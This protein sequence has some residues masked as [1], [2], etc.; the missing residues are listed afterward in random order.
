VD[1]IVA[2]VNQDSGV[3]FKMDLDVS[4]REMVSRIAPIAIYYTNVQSFIDKYTNFEYGFVHHALCASIDTFVQEYLT[5]IAQ[6]EHVFRKGDMTMQRFWF[7]V[8]PVFA[9]MKALDGLTKSIERSGCKGGAL[10]SLLYD[11]YI[12]LS[13]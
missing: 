1:G 7:Y 2:Q 9:R 12:S 11:R 5:L 10:L 6:L 8:Q 3:T 13:G 4:L